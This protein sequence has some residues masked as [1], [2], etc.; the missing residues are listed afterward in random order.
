ME[1]VKFVFIVLNFTFWFGGFAKDP[2]ENLNAVLS[3][4]N[5][6]NFVTEF[7]PPVKFALPVT[8]MGT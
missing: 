8:N 1:P 5:V 4:S 7:E 3:D 2:V 6:N